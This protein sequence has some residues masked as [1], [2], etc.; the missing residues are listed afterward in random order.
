MSELIPEARLLT[1]YMEKWDLSVPF[2]QV[3]SGTLY[4]FV[5]RMC[6]ELEIDGNSQ[7]D[8]IMND[9]RFNDD[10]A[11]VELRVLTEGGRQKVWCL[12]KPEA[13]M[14]IGEISSRRVKS[15]VRGRLREVQEDIKMYADKVIFGDLSNVLVVNSTPA[16]GGELHVG[17]CPRCRTPLLLVVNDQG[18]FLKL[19]EK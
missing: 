8:K 11:L 18:I 1:V 13:A 17:G 9:D 6:S 7:L 4:I 3:D 15:S 14:W 16:R 12:R 19:A 2:V 5:R 10:E